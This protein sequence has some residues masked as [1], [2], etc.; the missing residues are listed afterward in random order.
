MS[1]VVTIVGETKTKG[2]PRTNT[3]SAFNDNPRL[4]TRPAVT[5]R[6]IAKEIVL[7]TPPPIPSSFVTKPNIYQHYWQV[8]VLDKNG[9]MLDVPQADILSVTFTDVL[10]GGS[11]EGTI[12]F[13]RD[14]S[15]IGQIAFQNRVLIWIWPWFQ[16]RPTNPYYN[17]YM[18]DIDVTRLRTDGEVSV[19]IE[20]DQNLLSAAGGIYETINPGIGSN[21]NIDASSYVQHLFGT[22]GPPNFGTLVIP[23]SLFP[24]EPLQ[25]YGLKLDAA[26]DTV[27]KS[28]RDTLGN[29]VTWRVNS[30]ANGIRTLLVVPDQNPN[31]FPQLKFQTVMRDGMCTA[32]KFS[33][34]NRDIV[35]VI[36]VDG[37]TDPVSG[38]TVQAV[39]QEVASTS[40][41]GYF[42]DSISVPTLLS[43]TALQ[44]YGQAYCELHGYPQAQGTITLADPNPQIQAGTWIQ[45]FEST[46]IYKQVR[47]AKVTVKIMRTRV[48]QT[49]ETVA[50]TP[51]MDEAI[52]RTGLDSTKVANSIKGATGVDTQTTF[53]RTGLTGS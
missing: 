5:V 38:L 41:F 26:I 30:Y 4:T 35:N 33:T 22:Y 25:L 1:S 13:R 44:N 24:L 32:Y 10:N 3:K 42:T 14:P 29:L 48:E 53:S 28:G 27:L 47:V 40:Q 23:P 17:G 7:Y 19:T 15:N 43:T 8:F 11:G 37:G 31:K 16:N 52:Y 50:P 2:A 20:G 34:K 9:T 21:P 46:T 12:T 51:Y 6:P 18:V 36:S 49:L 39:Y 45:C